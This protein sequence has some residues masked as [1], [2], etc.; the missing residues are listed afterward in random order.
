M[1]SMAA[2][3]QSQIDLPID[4][5]QGSAVDY[6]MSSW[7]NISTTLVP[8]PENASNTVMRF[9]KNVGCGPYG[10]TVLGAG[11]GPLASD[12][13][14]SSTNHSITARI[15]STAPIG[16]PIMLKIENEFNGGIYVEKIVLTTKTNAWENII[17]DFSSGSPAINYSNV[18]KKLAFLFNIGSGGSGETYYVDNM[19]FGLPPVITSF[20]P[21]TASPGDVV[22]IS[23]S[24]FTSATAV[25]FGGFAAASYTVNSSSS[26]TATVGVGGTGSVSVTSPNQLT[27]SLAGFTFVPLA[28]APTVSSFTPTS[29]ATGATVNITGTN[30]SSATAV[31]FGGVAATSFTVNSAT[32]ISAVVDTGSSGNVSVVNPDGVGS[33]SGFTYI[34][35]A[36]TITT[37]TPASSGRGVTVSITG[38][39]F[40]DVSAVKFGGVNA[41]SYTVFSPTSIGA[42]VGAGSSGSV[43][44]T[45]SGG[46]GSKT[47]YNFLSQ[48]ALPINWEGTTVDYQT[49]IFGD[50]SASV[51]TDPANGA[52]KALKVLKPASAQVWGGV[53]LGNDAFEGGGMSASIPF[54][55]TDKVISARVNVPSAGV[56]ILCKVENKANG[57]INAQVIGTSTSAGWQT[58]YFDISGVDHTQ[59]YDKI[60]FFFDWLNAG[61]ASSIFYL[62]D[63]KF[64]PAPVITSFSPTSASAGTTITINGSNF[65][66]ASD[67]AFGG[68]AATSFTVVN[69]NQITATVGLGLTGSV[70]VTRGGIGSLA[71]F[72]FLAAANAP[73]I[74][75]FSPTT[76]G[77][78]QTV[79]INGTNF[80]TATDVEIGGVAALSFSIVSATQITAVVG[81]ASS[82]T[83]QVTNP[84]GIGSKAGFTMIPPA[85]LDLPITWDSPFSFDYS[86]SNFAAPLTAE[87]AADPVNPSNK[88]LKMVKPV[89]TPDWGGIVVGKD[90]NPLASTVPF[91]S[92][93]RFISMR[94]Y[95]TKPAGST[96]LMKWE[97]SAGG[98]AI[99]VAVNTTVQNAWETLYFDFGTD[100]NINYSGIG[101][102]R[103]VLFPNFGTIGS[104]AP[105]TFYFDDIQFAPGPNLTSFSPTSATSGTTITLNGNNFTGA[106]SV[107]FGGVN[108]TS[109]TVVNNNQITAV[110]G[111]G[112]T[113]AVEVKTFGTASLAGFNFICTLCPPAITTFSPTTANPGQNVTITGTDFTGATAVSF[114][115]TAAAS[116]TV[117]DASTIIAKV[118]TGATGSVSVTTA[119]GTGTKTGFTYEK[120][121]ASLP[122]NWE[123]SSTVDYAPV[124]FGGVNTAIVSDP[125]DASN[126]VL[127]ITK[128]AGS[129]VWAGTTIAG[130]NLLSPAVPFSLG[131]TLMSVRLYST[132]PVGKPVLLKMEG[133][134]PIEV[135]GATT[136]SNGWQVLTF[137]FS[138][139]VNINDVYNKISIFCGFTQG[140]SSNEVYYV[141][142]II[143]GTFNSNN[144]LGGTSSSFT[145]GSNWSLGFPPTDCSM[146]VTVS[147]WK[148]NQPTI[149]TGSASLG[150][151]NFQ[152]GGHISVASGASLSICGDVSGGGY[153]A[154]EG[155]LVMSGSTAQTINGTHSVK[156]LTITKPAS[157]GNV[158]IDGR[159]NVSGVVT[160]SNANANLV[161]GSTGNLTLLS[162][163]SGTGS[164]GSIPAGA[165]VNGDVTIQRY[166]NGTGDGW[167][168]LGG[169]VQGAAFSQWSDNLYMAAGTNL[170]GT[171]GIVGLGMQHSTIFKYDDAVHNVALDTVQ[172]NGWRVP[173]SSDDLGAGK[174]FRV[175][176]TAYN[177]AS[178][179]IDNVGSIHQ[180]NFTY[181]SLIRNEFTD[182]QPNIS[183]ATVACTENNR[184]WNLLSNPYPSSINWD[185]ASGWSKP[186]GIVNGFYRWN[187][188]SNGYGAYVAGT[189]VGAGPAPSNPGLIPSGQGFFVKLQTGTSASL[190]MTEAVKVNTQATMLRTA[191]EVPSA[192]KIELRSAQNAVYSFLGE[193][194][195]S[196]ESNDGIDADKDAP[197]MPSSG[198]YFTMPV[199]NEPLILNSMSSLSETKIIPL[200]VNKMGVNGSYEF[201]FSGMSSFPAQT[202]VFIRD[203]ANGTIQDLRVQPVYSFELNSAEN[204]FG[205]F[206][207]IVSPEIVTA[208]DVRNDSFGLRVYPNPTSGSFFIELAQS[209]SSNA[210]IIMTD[211]L[212]KVVMNK[213][214]GLESGKTGI[215]FSSLAGGIYTVKVS[216]DGKT[217]TRRISVQ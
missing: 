74:S 126:T 178:R 72:T 154:S 99:Q 110:V 191:S 206:E 65:L 50:I 49:T 6:S 121:Q 120:L 128:T 66:N 186:A 124:D 179:V 112:G 209:S 7:D 80:S 212:G 192:L 56:P 63:V 189:Y 28:T 44:V 84:D 51:V 193:L 60:V 1:V 138:G 116:F 134:N 211:M 203:N 164:I 168:L 135:Q 174:G 127:R 29:A 143:L 157:S 16:T 103:L 136:S 169:S 24:N 144:W 111:A 122:I 202:S 3:S 64:L 183:P 77:Y 96:I 159:V 195:F 19:V 196:S 148:P 171:Q 18:Y 36:P 86:I 114:G 210:R 48:I 33:K 97:P 101:Y 46:T 132:Q 47:G 117:V 41:A 194:R 42:I 69:D 198:F 10:G 98:A 92:V 213:A 155:T 20:A 52:N 104:A 73:T 88:V 177:T 158:T 182:C 8:D 106:T 207:L 38:T 214:V 160:L 108:A 25:E 22:S 217:Y 55:A 39:N 109:F 205:R 31:Y 17:F 27:G 176:L 197:V 23:G 21:T 146:D 147:G 57:G 100:A 78:G 58:I 5:D 152:S 32:S 166:L 140:A 82:G 107:K 93:N 172:K 190:S 71:G 89:G 142:N 81:G 150:S 113:G 15:Y 215:S 11:Y 14:F 54:T 165:S 76:A 61:S 208:A 2:Y 68:V 216:V 30:F 37:F 91:T 133:P 102:D 34:P 167:F 94:V 156:D 67:V 173:T 200:N 53:I 9:V 43:S 125:S 153:I 175:Y 161:V 170:G 149:S 85:Q 204:G 162:T 75:S 62:D 123:K 26:I 105:N 119:I 130:G 180:G 115:G 181:P 129:Q 90:Y 184:G 45:T 87:V 70:S 145:T 118:G 79:T 4:W 131:N 187:S 141:D 188:A 95:S 137:D 59:T 40:I 185:A 201:T 199:E 151:V 35:P 12:P 163:A 83:V 13:G 139:V